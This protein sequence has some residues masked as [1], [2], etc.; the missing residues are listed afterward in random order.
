MDIRRIKHFN[1]EADFIANRCVL[2]IP[3]V[4]Y[5]KQTDEV[6]FRK[7]TKL[8]PGQIVLWDTNTSERVY[9]MPSAYNGNDYPLSRYKPQGIVVIPEQF[10]PDGRAVM[11]SLVNMSCDTPETGKA[12]NNGEEITDVGYDIWLRWGG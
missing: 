6:Y 5:C 1:T 2:P 12:S 9:V 7:K 4:A 10:T 3:S 8:F 11:M